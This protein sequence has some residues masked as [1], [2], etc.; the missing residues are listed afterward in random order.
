MF[1][2]SIVDQLEEKRKKTQAMADQVL[3]HSSETRYMDMLDGQEQVGTIIIF[4]N[5]LE[6]PDTLICWM[7]RNR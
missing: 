7:D 2:R 3:E 1:F 5:I 4:W 6:K